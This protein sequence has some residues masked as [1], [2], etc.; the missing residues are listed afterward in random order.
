MGQLRSQ[1]IGCCSTASLRWHHAD[2]PPT[3][4]PS[5][6][7]APGEY[8]LPWAELLRRTVG[9][10][11][12]ICACGARMVVDDEVTDG[13]KITETLARLGIQSTGPPKRLQSTGELDYVYDV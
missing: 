10:D 13:E 2:P 1:L 7:R 11:P 6:G 12:E 8:W 4:K 3:G 5:T 9:V